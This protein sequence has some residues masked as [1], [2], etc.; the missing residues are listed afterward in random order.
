ME[1]HTYSLRWTLQEPLRPAA[2]RFFRNLHAFRFE[3]TIRLDIVAIHFTITHTEE[4]D[5][6]HQLLHIR[7]NDEKTLVPV[8]DDRRAVKISGFNVHRIQ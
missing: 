7:I 4:I 3:T 1:L 2:D 6:L 8:H 5:T